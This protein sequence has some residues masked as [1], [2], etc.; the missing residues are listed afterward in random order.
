MLERQ[1]SERV[2]AFLDEKAL[3]K[4]AELVAAKLAEKSSGCLP[5]KQVVAGSS[6]V[7]RSIGTESRLMTTCMSQGNR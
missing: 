4:L 6:P 7:S 2:P 1:S 5:S 3:D